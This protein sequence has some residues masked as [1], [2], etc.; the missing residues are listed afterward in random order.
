MYRMI[1]IVTTL[2]FVSGCASNRT[3]LVKS[4]FLSLQPTLTA[5]LANPP[6]VYE[7]QG[8]LVVDGQLEASEV[9]K[10][11]HVDVQVIAPDGTVVFGAQVNY[12]RP[13][14]QMPTGPR[15]TYRGPRSPA[16]SHATYSVTFPGLPPEGSVVRVKYDP[17]PHDVDG[18]K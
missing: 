5:S 1:L 7:R 9:T 6:E 16:D 13:A 8:A 4:G 17:Q 10:G 11:G 15:G 3:D 2:T 14:T 18:S 12:R